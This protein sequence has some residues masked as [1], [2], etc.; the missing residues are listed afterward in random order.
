MFAEIEALLNELTKPGF[1]VGGPREIDTC[2]HGACYQTF[3]FSRLTL[4]PKS[5]SRRV[6]WN[7]APPLRF[8]DVGHTDEGGVMNQ[9]YYSAWKRSTMSRLSAART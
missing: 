3:K 6:R 8:Y 5:C 2:L 9:E 7:I 1:F 4:F